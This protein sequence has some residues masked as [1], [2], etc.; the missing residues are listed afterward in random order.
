[1]LAHGRAAAQAGDMKFHLVLVLALACSPR[2]AAPPITSSSSSSS[3]SSSPSSPPAVSAATLAGRWTGNVDLPGQQLA[4][5]IRFDT[6]DTGTIDVPAQGVTGLAL[7]KISLAGDD[8]AFELAEV[9]ATFRGKLHGDA[10]AGTMAQNGQTPAFALTRQKA[11]AQAPSHAAIRSCRDR[12]VDDPT[13]PYRTVEVAIDSTGGA[14]LAGTLT[15]PAGSTRPPV[16]VLVTG[17]GPQDRDECVFGV[18]PF[19]QLADHLAR[20]GIASL[21]YDDRGTASST[22][23]FAGATP[24]DFADDA[25]AAVDFLASRRDVDTHGIGILGHSEGGIIAP[26]VA[27][28]DPAVAFI[29]LWAA[30]GQTMETVDLAQ[31]ERILRADGAPADVIARRVADERATI[32]ALK[33]SHDDDSF[34][35]ALRASARDRNIRDID[36]WV[37][38]QMRQNAGAWLRWY[39]GYDPAITL[40]KV[41]CPVLALGGSLDSQVPAHDNLEAIR[42]AL[43]HNP[44]ATASELPGLNHLFQRATTGGPSKY[45]SLPAVMD[46]TVLDA[47]ARWIAQRASP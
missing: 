35:A 13:P 14:R 33:A 47:T 17:S 19:R 20:H 16:V 1:M 12:P 3:S 36:A 42:A 34:A 32:A 4:I 10:I 31:T 46:P 11:G 39:V 21:R 22:G 45:A 6:G 9:G 18:R 29:V 24:D 30:P 38:A 5:E 28:R 37:A 27:T 40:A 23:R 44:H 8:V 15:L 25:R 2:S 41:R 26:L 43:G 7:S